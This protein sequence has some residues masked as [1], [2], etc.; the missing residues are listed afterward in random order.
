MTKVCLKKLSIQNFKGIKERTLDFSAGRLTLIKG[1]NGVG[2]TTVLTAWLWLICNRDANLTSNPAIFPIGEGEYTPTVEAE[3][4]VDGT[5]VT[6]KKSQKRRVSKP[7]ENGVS[8]IAMSNSYEINSVELSERD[9]YKSLEE[10]GVVAEVLLITSHTDSFVNMKAEEKRKMLMQFSQKADEAAIIEKAIKAGIKLDSVKAKSESYKLNEIEAM[11]KSTIRKIKE[12]YG[13]DGEILNAK[14]NGLDM[15]RVE[16]TAK[17][18][19]I[20][21]ELGEVEKAREAIFAEQKKA[22]DERSSKLHELKAISDDASEN[23]KSAMSKLE[24][25]VSNDNASSIVER[26]NYMSAASELDRAIA[27]KNSALQKAV[28]SKTSA[29]NSV[30]DMTETVRQMNERAE[31]SIVCPTCG[32]PLEADKALAIKQANEA[33]VNAIL[34]EIE[35]AQKAV[36]EATKAEKA[37]TSEIKDMTANREDIE[38]KLTDLD[39]APVKDSKETATLRKEVQKLKDKADKAFTEYSSLYTAPAPAV[40][41]E[42]LKELDAK[43]GELNQTLSSIKGNK[44]IDAKIAELREQQKEY[45]QAKADAEA[46]LDEID[47]LNRFSNE[48]VTEEINNH[49]TNVEWK[50][51]D[52]KKNGEYTEVCDAYIDGK[53]LGE[54]A[55]TGRE[56]VAKISIATGLQELFGQRVPLFV[57]GFESLSND[58]IERINGNFSMNGQLIGLAVTEDKE[59]VCE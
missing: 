27:E 1:R 18:S 14:I 35:N 46:T 43:A 41:V 39:S 4:T 19:D 48:L 49:F 24:K 5:P 26:R 21:K 44:E 22:Q 17:E 15:G 36:D 6:I 38:S 33:K 3:I 23:L 40:N 52:Y 32:R 37:L 45:E 9:F 55:N 47:R 25:S 10:K 53:K 29:Q 30:A 2:K 58:S 16:V 51:F 11:A 20:V 12:V 42:G 57:D 50:F 34:A 56:I 28:L 59:L 54:S 13:K 7:D 31:S 8:K